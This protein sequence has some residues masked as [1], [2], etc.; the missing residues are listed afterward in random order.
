[1]IILILT[2]WIDFFGVGVGN[3]KCL[4]SFLETAAISY[5]KQYKVIK[6]LQ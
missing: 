5:I 4:L 6:V 2:E 3:F 1:M